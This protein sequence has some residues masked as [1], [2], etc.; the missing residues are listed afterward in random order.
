MSLKNC[1]SCSSPVPATGALSRSDHLACPECGCPLRVA[2][3]GRLLASWAGLAAGWLTWFLA[4]RSALSLG[5]L[6]WF[7]PIVFAI[8][9]FGIA[10]PL[11]LFFTAAIEH[12]PPDPTPAASAPSSGQSHA[13]HH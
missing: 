1:P 8:L 4:S 9:A 12:R 6:G 2:A 11:S 3:D 13:G 10:S 5:P 7:L